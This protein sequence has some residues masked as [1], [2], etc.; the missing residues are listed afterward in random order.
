MPQ[1]GHLFSFVTLAEFNIESPVLTEQYDD[2]DEDRNDGAGA[3]TGGR[4]GSSGAAVPVVI[5]GTNLDSDGGAVG[6]RRVPGV[7]HNDRDLV[8]AC[9]QVGDPKFQLRIVT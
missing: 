8:D 2:A 1:H 4:H 3:E 5:T 6:Q 9:L 7:E